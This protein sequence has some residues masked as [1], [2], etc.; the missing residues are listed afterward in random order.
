M[1]HPL[2]KERRKQ[3]RRWLAIGAVLGVVSFGCGS[4]PGSGDAIGDGG[5]GDFA[6]GGSGGG[7]APT[8]SGSGGSGLDSG[9]GGAGG[10][11]GLPPFPE[12]DV[13]AFDNNPI[14]Q[15]FA[16][17]S[18]SPWDLLPPSS[19][20]SQGYIDSALACYAGADACAT[21]GC[22]AF[23][24]CCV[25]TGRCTKTVE[26]QPLPTSLSF[27]QCAGLTLEDCAQREGFSADVFGQQAP[28]LTERGLVPNGTATSE[29]GALLGDVVSL[30]SRR[31][32]VETQ[33]ALPIE[34]GA[35]CL[36][37]AAVAF[38]VHRVP[39]R[40]EGAE[41]GLLLSGSR[42]TVSL[43]IGGQVADSYDAGDDATVWRLVLSPSGEVVVERDG[44]IQGSYTFDPEA[45]R[46]ARLALF[47]RNLG[48]DLDSAAIARLATSTEI[49][50]SPAGWT[51][52]R[53]VTVLASGNVD[54]ELAM[55]REPS[56]AKGA[57]L[58][59]V[60]FEID[61]QIFVAEHEGSAV[62]SFL[63]P[64][65]PPVVF[66]TEPFEAGG[67]GDPELVWLSDSLY[68]FYTAYD[69]NGVGRIGSAL[70]SGNQAVK[71]LDPVLEPQGDVVSYDSPTLA[72][73]DGLALMVVRAT[74]QSGE[75]EL[76]AFYSPDPETGWERIVDGM[77][78]ELSRVG[79]PGAEL[80]SPSLIVHNS[81]YQLYY[82]R[83]AGTRWSIELLVSDE[84]LIWR[85][86]GEILGA[87]GDS[88]DSLGAQGADALSVIDG[89]EL[90]YSG[91]DGI[92][93][94]LGWARRPAP[95]NT[96]LQ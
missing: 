81:A 93:F 53:P 22:E 38:A 90:L 67:V 2:S 79:E 61:G 86:L 34:C 31:V 36:Q 11:S 54:S 32:V 20:G 70:I 65:P 64:E 6:A 9:A 75:T 50:D 58:T 3:R 72:L 4:D 47:G 40:F 26:P 27:E 23:A 56:I 59:A 51:D 46:E 42:G 96:A 41:V 5:E 19:Q 7:A 85:P 66:P 29:G 94:E 55:G 73:R 74:L 15:L 13:S 83:R 44:S 69:E 35:T 8:N 18:R 82:S 80:T 48:D 76:R 49:T 60:A 92:S 68:V 89:I 78:E 77:L 57:D 14:E 16:D 39:A 30:A 45:L 37:S 33:F 21:A 84:M 63:E 17:P 88:F 25:G 62:V 87:S 71:A 28:I 12:A 52:R 24:S 43:I 91:Q 10:R 95:S 1:E